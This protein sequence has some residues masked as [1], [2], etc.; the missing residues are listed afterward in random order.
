[1]R[2]EQDRQAELHLVALCRDGDPVAWEALNAI[3][4]V[5]VHLCEAGCAS[6]HDGWRRGLAVDAGQEV[7]QEWLQQ[8]A[9][10]LPEFDPDA[11]SLTTYLAHLVWLRSG[12]LLRHEKRQH[13]REQAAVEPAGQAR[14]ADI[15]WQSIVAEALPRLTP[16][17]RK[18]L[19]ALALGLWPGGAASL[20]NPRNR[21][22][23][24]RISARLA[25]HQE[26][27]PRRED[28]NNS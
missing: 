15:D 27:E 9:A 22:I 14:P 26:E 24:S 20:T 1:M 28:P 10:L 11:G 25:R 4:A 17:Q 16:A 2:T 13:A 6:R 23:W 21:K 18:A 7:A 12:N 19:T 5:A 3:L 8:G